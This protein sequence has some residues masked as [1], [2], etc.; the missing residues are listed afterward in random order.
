MRHSTLG[1]LA[2]LA[3]LVASC[4]FGAGNAIEIPA[5]PGPSTTV[6]PAIGATAAIAGEA[7]GSRG[8]PVSVPQVPF[9]PPEAPT[10]AAA[11]RAVYQVKLP[12]DLDHGFFVI[13]ELATSQA[14]TAA[15][16]E[17]VAY[18]ESGPGRVQF[19]PDARFVLRQV[20]STLIFYSWAPSAVTDERA[21]QIAD[22]LATVGMGYEIR[23]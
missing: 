21:P 18:V 6:T 9:R 23:A 15:A 10:L 4:G 19:P 13:Y 5:A 16:E 3:A 1:A 17:Q 7:L 12:N 11:P 22:A 14:A 2:A 8:L 20:G